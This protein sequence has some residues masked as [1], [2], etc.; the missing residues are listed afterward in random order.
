MVVVAV[1]CCA[2]LL[3]CLV[4][5]CWGGGWVG[6]S[7]LL[8]TWSVVMF[9]DIILTVQFTYNFSMFCSTWCF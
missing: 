5:F 2:G 1:A 8:S 3:T 6:G 9:S 7:L 4:C